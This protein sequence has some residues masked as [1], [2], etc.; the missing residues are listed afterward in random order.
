MRKLIWA[1][2]LG[3][4]SYL[5]TRLLSSQQH[6]VERYY[7]N[8]LYPFIAALQS[9]TV[10]RFS[11]SLAEILLLLFLAYPVIYLLRKRSSKQIARLI[12]SYA[13]IIC[14]LY[15]AFVALWGLNY[16]RLPLADIMNLETRPSSAAEL[17]QLAQHLIEQAN[18][19]RLL[20]QEDAEGVMLLNGG[21][22]ESLAR[23][24]AGYDIA[25]G[26]VPELAGTYSTPKGA[27]LSTALSYLG[28]AGIYSPFTGEAHVNIGMPDSSIAVTA[29]HEAA[30]QRG[31][32]REDEANFIAYLVC[33]MHP[34]ADFRY[35]GTLLALN[36]TM[37]ALA[38]ADRTLFL[39][40]SAL[41]SGALRRD[42]ASVRSFWQRY[43]GPVER[44][45]ERVND[46]YLRANQQ[47][48]GVASY[49]RMVDLLLAHARAYGI[50]VPQEDSAQG[51]GNGLLFQTEQL[52]PR[53]R[54]AVVSS[55][56]G[57]DLDY[58]QARRF[59]PRPS[60]ALRRYTGVVEHF[61]VHPLIPYPAVTFAHRQSSGFD[62]WFVTADEFARLLGELYAGNF[63][64]V[65]HDDVYEAV[66]VSGALRMR[67]RELWLPEGK[68]PLIISVD[69][70]NYYTYMREAGLPDRLVL[71][72]D[73]RV[74]VLGRRPDGT[75][76][77]SR[78]ACV[79]PVLDAF[80]ARFPDFSHRGAK[81][82]IALTG[83]EGIL[84]YRT[85]GTNANRREEQ[86][87]VMPVVRALLQTGWKFASHSF[88]HPDFPSMSYAGFVADADR[89]QT[90]VRSLVGPVSVMIYPFGARVPEDSTKFA[91]LLQQGFRIFCAV[92]PTAFEQ[93]SRTRAAVMTDRRAVDGTSL[94]QRRHEAVFS[95][96]N[97]INLAARPIR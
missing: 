76:Y 55:L 25:R 36:H 72:G 4:M 66:A 85:Q 62:D 45:A 3:F 1:A 90:E 41:Y 79:V 11:H 87:A 81:G 40:A 95:A 74:S 18:D 64:L 5:T 88:G 58:D 92:G 8:F 10:G 29:V 6:L 19:L 20:V 56:T 27:L 51:H 84:G 86:K 67:R 28:I 91:Y 70:M 53:L 9:S 42:L 75:Q 73:G 15:F 31:F 96:A 69:D 38:R 35:S 71:D 77:V 21:R 61:F 57:H 93:I 33:S 89:W 22:R 49:G 34:D 16:L 82:I 12:L 30:H 52:T 32:S 24:Q 94:R 60:A 13:T 37:N 80:V 83:Y 39:E 17:S 43:E 54:H 44:A 14:L 65:S 50:V 97:V 59:A 2:A 68:K 47:Q 78:T 46:A 48:D 23:V 63:I 7:A 26:I